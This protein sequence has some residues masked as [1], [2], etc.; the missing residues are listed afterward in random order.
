MPITTLLDAHCPSIRLTGE[1]DM[2]VGYALIDEIK[3]L[4]SYYQFRTVELQIDSPG[5]S[6]EALQYIVLSMQEWRRGKGHVLRTVALNEVCSAAAIMLSLGT[7]GHRVASAHS[8]LLYHPARSTTL[9]GVTQTVPQLRVVGRRLEHWNKYSMNLLIEH[10][11]GS[12]DATEYRKRLNKLFRQERFISGA[13][14]CEFRLID[15]VV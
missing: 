15:R 9:S 11:A 3:L 8:R 4:R 1:I 14:A 7:V 5:G 10:V 12:E 2:T 13:E 6:A